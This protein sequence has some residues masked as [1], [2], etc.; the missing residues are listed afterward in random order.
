MGIIRKVGIG[1]WVL[2]IGRRHRHYPISNIQYLLILLL[3]LPL[4]SSCA[5]TRPVV[6]IGLLAPFEGVYRQEGYDALAAMRA[7]IEEQNPSGIDVLPL[8]LDSSLDGA[9]AAQKVLADPS[10]VTVVGPYWAAE[11]LSGGEFFDGDRWQHPFAPS[12]DANWTVKAVDAAVAFAEGERRRLVLAG[13]PPGWP[14]TD[15]GTVA[16]ADDV[17][18][19]QAVLWL[20]DAALGADFAQALWQ[21]LPDAP[22]GLYAAGVETFRQRLEKGMTGLLFVVGWIDDDYAVWAASHSPNTPAVYAVYRLTADTLRRLADETVTTR[23]QPAIFIV[24]ND[25]RLSLAEG[26]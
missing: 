11:A 2:D 19:G 26:R 9:R 16:G 1:Y 10:V 7:A 24:G 14:Q 20:G 21:R 17:Q 15:V 18:A 23:W 12:G 8:A 6:K 22:I 13:I 5:S 3:A 4:L 25:G